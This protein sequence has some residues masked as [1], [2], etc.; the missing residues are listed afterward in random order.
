MGNNASS[1]RRIDQ[2]SAED[3]H[4]VASLQPPSHGGVRLTPWYKTEDEVI[5]PYPQRLGRGYHQDISL[6]E[7]LEL[8]ITDYAADDNLIITNPDRVHP[9]ELTYILT[10][11]KP[12]NLHPIHAGEH[13][14]CGSGLAPKEIRNIPAQQLILE[15]SIHIDPS[16]FRQ[17]LTG[18]AESLL[19][20]IAPLSKPIISK[21]L[22][23]PVPCSKL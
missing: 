1:Q 2:R 12:S 14:F 21:F 10:D 5:A 3:L 18:S 6:R 7:G 11:I 9:I 20:A 23:Q 16:L 17:W 4:C 15:V 19:C 13:S 22:P 8:T